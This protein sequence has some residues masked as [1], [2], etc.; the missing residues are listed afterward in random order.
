[1]IKSTNLNVTSNNID[2]VLAETEAK[3]TIDR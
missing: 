2:K 3:L 1:M